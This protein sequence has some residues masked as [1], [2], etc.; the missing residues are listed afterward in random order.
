GRQTGGCQNVD[1]N[2]NTNKALLGY[3]LDGKNRMI[4][5]IDEED[6]LIGRNIFRMMRDKES[7]KPALFLERY[8]TINYSKSFEEQIIRFAIQRAKAL[9]V[10][11]YSNQNVYTKNVYGGSLESIGCNA[12]FE[13]SDAGGGMSEGKY[14]IA[15]P[16]ILY[17]PEESKKEEY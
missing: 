8:Y 4:G 17:Q 9:K 7:Q 12:P 5:A 16:Y 13:Y 10:P 15:K 3:V 11:L 14:E 6:R 1:G 2:A